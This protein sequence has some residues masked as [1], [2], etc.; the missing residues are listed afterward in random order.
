MNTNNGGAVYN[1]C[2]RACESGRGTSVNVRRPRQ[3]LYD[4]VA[5]VLLRSAFEPRAADA[6]RQ[7]VLLSG[8]GPYPGQRLVQVV[9]VGEYSYTAACEYCPAA[10]GWLVAPGCLTCCVLS[11]KAQTYIFK[12]FYQV[13]PCR[14]WA[15]ANHWKSLPAG[16]L[17][18]IV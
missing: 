7:E 4:S 13:G 3:W 14:P 9:G 12:R 15:T 16:V 10:M 1:G 8:R 5:A 11:G 2:K 18:T 17:L 6:C